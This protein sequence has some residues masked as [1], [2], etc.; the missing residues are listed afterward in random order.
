MTK[1]KTP[2]TQTQQNMKPEQ[3]DSEPDQ[4]AQNTDDQNYAE[5]PGAE[6]ATNRSPRMVQTDAPSRNTEPETSAH[7]GS[8]STRTPKRPVQG[9]TS[10][11]AVE[12]SERQERVVTDRPDARA[13]LNRSK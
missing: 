12:E 2:H 11:S 5:T 1:Q 6:T 3:T 7:E 9:V 8:V 4:N 10:H 13:G